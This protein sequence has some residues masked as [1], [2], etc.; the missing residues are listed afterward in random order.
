MPTTEENISFWDRSYNWRRRGDEWSVAWGGVDMQWHALIL[1]R[2]H[3]F[4]PAGTILEIGPG[5]GRWT[6][7][8]RDLCEHLVLVDLSEKCIQACN[9]RF[10]SFPHVASYVNDGKSLD[11]IPD[12]SVDFVFSFDSLVHAEED[13]IEAYLGQLSR[14]LKKD[15]VGVVHHSNAGEIPR[16]HSALSR[17]RRGRRFLV[18]LG[19]V[20]TVDHWRAYSMTAG[21][22]E[23][24]AEEA[25][26]Q[27]IS[28]ELVNWL[29]GS[30]RLIDCIS[31]FTRKGSTWVRPN[32]TLENG[33]FMKEVS[34]ASRLAELYGASSFESA[35]ARPPRSPSSKKRRG[36][37]LK[38]AERGSRM[39]HIYLRLKSAVPL[40]VK[41]KIKDEIQRIRPPGSNRERGS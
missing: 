36:T 25:G 37:V 14:K 39:D 27:C 29:T 13:V 9:E 40:P 15:G 30:G 6:Q 10:A 19:L 7:F 21:K 2:I 5:F 41:Q 16:Y 11:M 3:M 24:R 17:L 23:R 1:P 33:E 26:L 32:R 22:F 12:E 31:V 20:D 34:N 8:L 38:A 35:R 18:R 28:Q 4:V